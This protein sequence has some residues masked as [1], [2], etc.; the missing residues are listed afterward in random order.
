MRTEFNAVVSLTVSYPSDG[1][2]RVLE[3]FPRLETLEISELSHRPAAF[4]SI[5][6]RG[7]PLNPGLLPEQLW[8]LKTLR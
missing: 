2:G 8:Q 4:D 7:V 3:M 5:T 6:R 1:L